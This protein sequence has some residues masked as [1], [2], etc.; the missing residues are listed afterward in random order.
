[1][2]ISPKI[3][4]KLFQDGFRTFFDLWGYP[5]RLHKVRAA[6][7]F[8]ISFL[9]MGGCRTYHRTINQMVGLADVVG[10]L[11]REIVCDTTNEEIDPEVTSFMKVGSE[12]SGLSLYRAVLK[13]R[14]TRCLGCAVSCAGSKEGSRVDLAGVEVEVEIWH[15]GE[16]V[17]KKKA[18]LR[19]NWFYRGKVIYWNFGSICIVNADCHWSD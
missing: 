6:M 2:N 12:G 13:P 17:R 7:L 3:G 8:C 19:C 1:M 5:N 9:L 4:C 16:L 11:A 15:K 18:K 10:S 14:S